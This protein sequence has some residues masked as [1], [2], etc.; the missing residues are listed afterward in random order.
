MNSAFSILQPAPSKEAIRAAQ[1]AFQYPDGLKLA[2]PPAPSANRSLIYA[3]GESTE[4][5]V[6]K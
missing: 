6:P 3:F 5:D 4:E 2:V 1:F